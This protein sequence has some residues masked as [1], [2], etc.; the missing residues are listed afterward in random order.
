VRE[1][2]SAGQHHIAIPISTV[3][4]RSARPFTMPANCIAERFLFCPIAPVAELPHPRWPELNPDRLFWS[5]RLELVLALA[6]PRIVGDYGRRIGI[7]EKMGQVGRELLL[8]LLLICQVIGH[9]R[10]R[11]LLA[12]PR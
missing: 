6:A 3:I 11:V 7:L 5:R 4:P 2:E 12:W 10:K 1:Y 9:C 8:Q